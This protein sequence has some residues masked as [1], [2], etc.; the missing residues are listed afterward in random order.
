MTPFGDGFI[1]LIKM[2]LAS[3][4]SATVFVGIAHV[5][6]LKE[7]GKAAPKHRGNSR[8]SIVASR[9]RFFFSLLFGEA[10][11]RRSARVVDEGLRDR[12]STVG[13]P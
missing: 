9:C 13:R 2:P 10:M 11:S 1:R 5:G 7:V 12:G 6:D 4:V 3:V 8:C